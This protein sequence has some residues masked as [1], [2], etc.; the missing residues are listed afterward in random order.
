MKLRIL[1][2]LAIFSF[3]CAVN[4]CAD[5]NATLKE[6]Y[7]VTVGGDKITLKKDI[8]YPVMG[9]SGDDVAINLGS[10]TIMI[11]KSK[12][13]IIKSEDPKKA[14]DDANS[15]TS[16]DNET[17]AFVTDA[18]NDDPFAVE[19]QNYP[20]LFV[21]SGGDIFKVQQILSDKTV[22]FNP[23][24]ANDNAQPS[25]KYG[26]GYFVTTTADKVPVPPVLLTMTN[27]RAIVS[28]VPITNIVT[29]D[30][31]EIRRDVIGYKD[32]RIEYS[33]DIK[34]NLAIPNVVGA[35]QI[36]YNGVKSAYLFYI[37]TITESKKVSVSI[38]IDQVSFD[39]S[40]M[41]DFYIFSNSHYCPVI[42]LD[43]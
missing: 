18:K 4:L 15:T 38:P 31:V 29:M 42:K 36:D 9:Y 32:Y 5:T 2:V 43:K 41:D 8:A 13:N 30:G 33:C 28:K 39:S 20:V 14:E 34:T 24:I 17:S 12:L 21:K 25:S 27:E 23:K 40:N 3:I 37:G 19:K 16:K 7:P 22:A 11:P 26:W 35:V 6:D 1:A 10:H